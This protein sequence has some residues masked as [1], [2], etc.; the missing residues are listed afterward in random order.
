MVRAVRKPFW[1]NLRR[2]SPSDMIRSMARASAPGSFGGTR[3][4]VE[5]VRH[6]GRDAAHIAG[7]DGQT[8]G[9]RFHKHARRPF[10]KRGEH[11]QIR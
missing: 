1:I 3:Q 10:R 8:V 5:P 7:N 6:R 9:P 4:A 2:N 11:K